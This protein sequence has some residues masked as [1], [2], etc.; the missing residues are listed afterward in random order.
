M[1]PDSPTPRGAA[2]VPRSASA[3]RGSGGSRP[4]NSATGYAAAHSLPATRCRREIQTAA[5]AP[6]PALRSPWAGSVPYRSPVAAAVHSGPAGAAPAIAGHGRPP[7]PPPE[8]GRPRSAGPGAGT[9]CRPTPVPPPARRSH[10]QATTATDSPAAQPSPGPAARGA[11][12]MPGISGHNETLVAAPGPSGPGTR[13][14]MQVPL[15]YRGHV[16]SVNRPY[17]RPIRPVQPC[18]ERR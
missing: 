5:G 15:P 2:A 8:P 11:L 1:S 14:V 3:R 13:P 9:G 18:P 17:P 6:G 12:E 4:G 10:W 7:A 16:N